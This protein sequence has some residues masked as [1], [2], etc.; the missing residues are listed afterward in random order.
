MDG[1]GEFLDLLPDAAGRIIGMAMDGADPSAMLGALTV[2]MEEIGSFMTDMVQGYQFQMAE[3]LGQDA[4][5]LYY[6]TTATEGRLSLDDWMD[7]IQAP[8]NSEDWQ[9]LLFVAGIQN[10][11]D[12]IPVVGVLIGVAVLDQILSLWRDLAG[13]LGLDKVQSG[14]WTGSI[15][16]PNDPNQGGQYLL[17]LISSLPQIV[18]SIMNLIAGIRSFMEKR[19][20]DLQG[21]GEALASVGSDA[22]VQVLTQIIHTWRLQTTGGGLPGIIEAAGN[23]PTYPAEME[24]D[25]IVLRFMILAPEIH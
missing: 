22:L 6:L 10:P 13:A 16:D 20:N 15:P 21:I 1:L 8:E 2:Y 3:S 23:D 19:H 11:E 17:W 9:G 25:A 12:L 7:G 14:S 18:A 4:S 24:T 5:V